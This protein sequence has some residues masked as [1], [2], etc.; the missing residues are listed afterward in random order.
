M[1]LEKPCSVYVVT[2]RENG[3]NYVGIS[4]RIVKRWKEHWY[5]ARRGSKTYFS[6][7]LRQYGGPEAFT[8]EILQVFET[9]KTAKQAEKWLIASGVGDYNLT[10]GGDGV[11]NPSPETIAKSIAT[12]KANKKPESEETRKRRAEGQLNRAPRSDEFKAK[13]SSIR[14]GKKIGP[15]SEEHKANIAAANTGRKLSPE[16]LENLRVAKLGCKHTPQAIENMKNSWKLRGPVSDETRA[17]ISAS[18]LE[19]NSAR[20]AANN[21][22]NPQV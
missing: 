22:P 13:M 10:A 7:A 14:A 3:H 11:V 19:Y 12:R 15:M 16:T 4:T 1:A 21:Q 2:N 18:L 6:R 5:Q 9:A 17:K 8:W 20:V